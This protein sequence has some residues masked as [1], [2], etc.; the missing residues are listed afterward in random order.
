MNFLLDSSVCVKIALQQLGNNFLVREMLESA[1]AHFFYSAATPWEIAIKY[2]KGK[3]QIDGDDN[4]RLLIKID[5]K[6]IAILSQDGIKAAKL[7]PHHYDPFDRLLISHAQTHGLTILTTDTD[8]DA[9]D[10]AVVRG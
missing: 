2:A 6:E 5:A 10:V 1:D 3:L 9:Y 8:F 7:P 4:M